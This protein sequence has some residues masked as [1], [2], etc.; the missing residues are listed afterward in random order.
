[1]NK[2]ELTSEINKADQS[3]SLFNEL[4]DF[5]K[6]LKIE[7][8]SY[9]MQLFNHEK[10]RVDAYRCLFYCLS[11]FFLFMSSYIGVKIFH[12][13]WALPFGHMQWSNIV[14]FLLAGGC[15]LASAFVAFFM[16]TEIEVMRRLVSTSREKLKRVYADKSID[17]SSLEMN[18]FEKERL[19]IKLKHTYQDAKERID[20]LREETQFLLNKIKQVPFMHDKLK[21]KL[22]NQ[23]LLDFRLK[24]E[25]CLQGFELIA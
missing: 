14:F 25:G 12:T 2:K 24:S 3:P 20:H 1:M 18:L 23:V 9:K 22:F 5:K 17:L 8:V 4:H 11:L 7:G 21:N 16:R 10:K 15:S 13:G 6:M 19:T